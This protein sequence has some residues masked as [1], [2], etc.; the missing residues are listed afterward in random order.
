MDYGILGFLAFLSVIVIAIGI[1]RVWFYATVR[2]DDY[3]DKRK[4]ELDLHRRLTLVATIGSNA[5][6]VGLL[7]TVTGI[8]I[9]FIELG[10]TSA[11]DTKAI[12][13]GLALAL[14]STGMGLIVAIPSVVIYN[15]LVRKS[16]IIATKWDI[17]HHP[18]TEGAG[19]NRLDTDF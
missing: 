10:N 18:A 13:V 3:K 9:T 17:Y 1:E 16:E 8:M 19:Y 14:K 15:M 6:Y 12:M 11:V 2:V 5:P 7:G 4:L